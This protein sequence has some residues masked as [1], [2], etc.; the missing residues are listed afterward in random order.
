MKSEGDN[1]SCAMGPSGVVVAGWETCLELRG[2]GLNGILTKEE[3]SSANA[4]EIE[5]LCVSIGRIFLT[6]MMTKYRG[7]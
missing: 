4:G 1:G 6:W 3:Y 5:T 2:G 7:T